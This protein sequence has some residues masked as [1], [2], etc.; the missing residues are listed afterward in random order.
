M[1]VIVWIGVGLGV[2]GW[3]VNAVDGTKG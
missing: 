2:L 1:Q 3:I